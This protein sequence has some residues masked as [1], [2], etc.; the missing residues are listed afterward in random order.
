[1]R[2]NL[3]LVAIV[4]LVGTMM[5]RDTTAAAGI[6]PFQVV[7]GDGWLTSNARFDGTSW[8][9]LDAARPS[10]GLQLNDRNDIPFESGT[11]GATVWVRQPHCTRPITGFQERCGW[12]LGIAVTQFRSL[13]VGGHGIELDGLADPPYGRV[14]NTSD[15]HSRLIGIASNVFADFSGVD[16]ADAPS[17]L[18]AIDASSDAYV[19]KR[20]PRGTRAFETLLTVDRAGAL[21]TQRVDQAAPGRF[22]TRVRLAGGTYTFSFATPFAVTPVCVASAEGGATLHVT[23]STTSCVVRSTNSAD[24]GFV[25]IIVVGNPA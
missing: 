13:V 3:L 24:D 25:D 19:L 18:A 11:A 8:A 22:A 7:R 20:A 1:M 23:P 17:W 2:I 10:F 4:V 21:A 5:T 9:A 12:Q 16:R 6:S 14:V 15:G